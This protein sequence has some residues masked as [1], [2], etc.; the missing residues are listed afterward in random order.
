MQPRVGSVN[1]V[2][3]Q[4]ERCRR[5]PFGKQVADLVC[6]RNVL[7]DYDSSFLEIGHVE[8][9]RLDVLRLLGGRIPLLPEV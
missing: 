3:E 7:E 9:S 6:G 4:S 5:Q 1:L 2:S 8:M